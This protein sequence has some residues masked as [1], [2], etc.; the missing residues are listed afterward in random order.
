MSGDDKSQQPHPWTY[1][2]TLSYNEIHMLSSS[3]ATRLFNES[4]RHLRDV[5]SYCSA[6]PPKLKLD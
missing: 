3:K 4:L 1:N 5:F 6:P 2:L